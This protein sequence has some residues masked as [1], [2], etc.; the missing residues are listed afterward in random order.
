MKSYFT[1]FGTI[2]RLRLSRNKKTGAPKHYGFIEFE[3]E[4]V[5]QIVQE[6]MD[7]YL[8]MGHLL[9]VK[10]V[11]KDKVHPDLFKGANRKWRKMP[12]NRRERVLHDQPRTTADQKKVED[13]LLQ[14]QSQRQQALEAKGIDYD[15]PGCEFPRVLVKRCSPILRPCFSQQ[16]DQATK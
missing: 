11:P 6:T 8:I 14:R 1:Q 2:T 4:E 16:P 7:N 13:K 3:D 12:S 10:T 15:F 5:A 9:Q